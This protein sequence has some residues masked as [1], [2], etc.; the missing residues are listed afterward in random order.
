[1]HD[2]V[3][4]GRLPTTTVVDFHL[5]TH[6]RTPEYVRRQRTLSVWSGP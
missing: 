6:V 5:E 2:R 3:Y 4:A 1:M